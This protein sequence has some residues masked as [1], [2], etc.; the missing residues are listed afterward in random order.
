MLCGSRKLVQAETCTETTHTICNICKV[1]ITI[2]RAQNLELIRKEN[3][4]IGPI[5]LR[6]HALL[7]ILIFIVKYF[8]SI[9]YGHFVKQLKLCKST[10]LPKHP[11]YAVWYSY[12]FVSENCISMLFPI[13]IPLTLI[14]AKTTEGNSNPSMQPHLNFVP[15]LLAFQ[16]A[17][18]KWIE[19]IAWASWTYQGFEH[20][21]G[22]NFPNL[23][24]WIRFDSAPW[25]SIH[26]IY[27]MTKYPDDKNTV[28]K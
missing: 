11:N 12:S 18:R 5:E 25:I 17:T 7:S 9:M 4:M 2:R 15:L 19:A 28:T 3:L 1:W 22:H 21:C 14:L 16:M 13:L 26:K 8:E 6:T 20:L 10:R 27:Q 24:H 23:L